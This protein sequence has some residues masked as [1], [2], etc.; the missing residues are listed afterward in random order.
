MQCRCQHS[1]ASS[2]FH[3]ID[4]VISM[5][6]ATSAVWHP[7]LQMALGCEVYAVS[8]CTSFSMHCAAHIPVDVWCGILF[9]TFLHDSCL[10]WCVIIYVMYL[11]SWFVMLCF[12]IPLLY[13]DG[14]LRLSSCM[15]CIKI[16]FKPCWRDAHH[17]WVLC[18]TDRSF[19]IESSCSGTSLGATPAWGHFSLYDKNINFYVHHHWKHL[20]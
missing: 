6:R 18:H 14:I 3:A 4:S 11:L 2:H 13:V 17:A 20:M 10:M 9:L 19:F 12:E 16:P 5:V 15:F 1:C 7:L 8:S